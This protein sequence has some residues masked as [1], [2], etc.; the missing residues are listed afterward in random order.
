VGAADHHVGDLAAAVDEHA[1]LAA[2]L[3]AHLG[4]LAREL[5]A[6]EPVGGQAAA[7]QSVE[8]FG[9]TGLQAVRVP[10]DLDGWSPACL[11]R[12]VAPS[13]LR[14]VG[15]RRTARAPSIPSVIGPSLP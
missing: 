9:L 10:V 8:S 3:A 12:P 14:R 13:P 4:E 7:E 1:D 5:V 11:Q 15:R 6:D 2:D